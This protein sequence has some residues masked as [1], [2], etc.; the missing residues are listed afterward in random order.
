MKYEIPDSGFTIEVH[1]KAVI[2][3]F[4]QIGAK[5]R[6]GENVWIGIAT[7][8]PCSRIGKNTKIRYE[9]SLEKRAQLAAS[10]LT[11]YV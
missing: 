11:G 10:T 8:G 5:A 7:I 9:P 3:D 4:A 2:D 1:P 6:I